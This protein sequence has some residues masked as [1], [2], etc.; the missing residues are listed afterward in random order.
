MISVLKRNS[1]NRGRTQDEKNF[2][3]RLDFLGAIIIHWICWCIWRIRRR[4]AVKNVV[5]WNKNKIYVFFFADF[6]KFF[7]TL[8]NLLKNDLKNCKLYID[9]EPPRFKQDLTVEKQQWFFAFKIKKIK[10]VT[11][12]LIPFPFSFS[13]KTF[14]T[15]HFAA[16]WIWKSGLIKLINYFLQLNLLY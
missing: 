14:A 5:C 1:Q 9:V 11:S 3:F 16:Q 4:F 13:S 7:R 10:T 2:W 15:L 12:I 6:C 8:K